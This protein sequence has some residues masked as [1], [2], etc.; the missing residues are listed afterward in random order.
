MKLTR[1]GV[2]TVCALLL[3]TSSSL[4]KQTED[5]RGF[6]LGEWQG[7]VLPNGASPAQLPTMYSFR[8]HNGTLVGEVVIFSE[9]GTLDIALIQDP[10]IVNDVLTFTASF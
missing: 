10:H 9:S 8:L 3:A 5:L 1:Y 2:L 4:G 7:I 6:L